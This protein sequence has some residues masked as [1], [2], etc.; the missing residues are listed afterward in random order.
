MQ[1]VEGTYELFQTSNPKSDV[2]AN[3][4]PIQKYVRQSINLRAL[5]NTGIDLM[6]MKGNT[7]F[8]IFST[9]PVTA[10]FSPEQSRSPPPSNFAPPPLSGPSN[11]PPPPSNFAPPPTANFA[12]PPS[13]AP[14]PGNFAPP[15]PPSFDAPPPP[16][17]NFDMPLPPPMSY[18]SNDLPPPPPPF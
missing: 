17:G 14:P 3:S 13:F 5:D 18:D 8:V 6:G 1:K 2:P 9:V 11:L 4:R 12:A 15:P 10:T 16:P 7:D